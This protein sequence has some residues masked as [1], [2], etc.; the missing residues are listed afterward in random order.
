M[1]TS[2]LAGHC[3]RP[4]AFIDCSLIEDER[5]K[6]G[7]AVTIMI[8]VSGSRNNACPTTSTELR[9][10]FENIAFTMSMRMCSLERSVQGEH[11][12]NTMLNSTHCS[13]SHELE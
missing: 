7:S 12:R 10:F 11:S 6:K 4:P 1:K 5:R 3:G 9:V 2:D 8:T 13:S